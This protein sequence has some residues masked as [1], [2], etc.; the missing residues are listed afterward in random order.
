MKYILSPL[1]FEKIS[2]IEPIAKDLLEYDGIN[3]LVGKAKVGKTA[4]A[5]KLMHWWLQQEKLE[6]PYFITGGKMSS[7]QYWDSKFCQLHIPVSTFLLFNGIKRINYASTK[8]TSDPANII[9]LALL[10]EEIKITSYCLIII[11]D[12]E[13][14]IND[15]NSAYTRLLLL[16]LNSLRIKN[17]AKVFFTGRSKKKIERIIEVLKT[18][19]QENFMYRYLKLERPAY[20]GG[21]IKE[22]GECRIWMGENKQSQ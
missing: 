15:S 4:L 10:G 7:Y 1:L 5:Y 21:D 6:I 11:D 20:I 18:E 3:F 9:M 13:G 12:W 16:Q 14:I 22:F 17:K 2:D 8:N 19:Q